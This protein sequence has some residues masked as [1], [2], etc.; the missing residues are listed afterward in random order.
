MT[1]GYTL[2]DLIYIRSRDVK[3][4]DVRDAYSHIPINT[5]QEI[6]TF[7]VPQ[8]GPTCP[9]SEFKWLSQD[10][11]HCACL[12]YPICSFSPSI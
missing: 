7:H 6:P 5:V 1:I 3:A 12:T 2:E 9:D 10:R 8:D 4:I 11:S